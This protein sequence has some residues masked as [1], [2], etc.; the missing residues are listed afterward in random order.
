MGVASSLGISPFKWSVYQVFLMPRAWGFACDPLTI[1]LYL[2]KRCVCLWQQHLGDSLVKETLCLLNFTP[3]TQHGDGMKQ[4]LYLNWYQPPSLPTQQVRGC[5]TSSRCTPPTLYEQQ[6]EFFY[7]SQESEQYKS[8]E[9]RRK[10][11][12][13][14][15]RRLE[16]LTICRCHN[17]ASTFS[18]VILRPECWSSWGLNLWPP[19]Q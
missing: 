5:T 10:V 8:C 11:F 9:M 13:P 7:V 12:R 14:Y 3:V 1:T 16:C 6:C 2:F 4:D 19:A 15:P 17:K 18:S